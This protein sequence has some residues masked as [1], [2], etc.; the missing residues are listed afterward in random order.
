MIDNAELR[1]GL[2]EEECG[3]LSILGCCEPNGQVAHLSVHS[4]DSGVQRRRG[5]EATDA[6]VRLQRAIGRRSA[7]AENRGPASVRVQPHEDHRTLFDVVVREAVVAIEK[8][9]SVAL[10][11]HLQRKGHVVAEDLSPVPRMQVGPP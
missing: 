6:F 8:D 7:I 2:P 5:S 9:P 11:E 4:N 3:F 10:P 1:N